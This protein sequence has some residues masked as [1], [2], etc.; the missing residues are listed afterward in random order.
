MRQLLD[1]T[2]NTNSNYDPDDDD[3]DELEEP[4]SSKIRAVYLR[5]MKNYLS[6]DL[7]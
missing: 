3:P 4:V 1:K 7:W 5:W 2:R 6:I